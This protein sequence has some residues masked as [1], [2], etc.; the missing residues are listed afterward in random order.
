M[1]YKSIA[2]V[3]GGIAGLYAAWRMLQTDPECTVCLFEADDLLGGRIKSVSVPGIPFKAELGAMRF[4]SNH[5]LLRSLLDELRIPTR[6]FDVRPPRLK[7]RGRSL[8]A[9][10]LAD[11]SC[12]HC[13]AGAPY[14]LRPHERGKTAEE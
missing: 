4:R 10:E 9:K 6:R 7:V 3:G 12:R 5:L 1:K 14:L 13:G 8:S 11:G 2:I